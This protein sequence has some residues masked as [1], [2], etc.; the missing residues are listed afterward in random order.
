MNSKLA[1]VLLL[2]IVIVTGGCVGQTTTDVTPCPNDLQT[3]IQQSIPMV[4]TSCL[5]DYC[6]EIGVNRTMHLD[7]FSF[8]SSYAKG[9][10]TAICRKGSSAGQNINYLYCT[11]VEDS[12]KDSIY[13]KGVIPM[14]KV[15]IDSN[16]NI[17]QKIFIYVSSLVIDSDHNII[18][19]KCMHDRFNENLQNK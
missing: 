17:V 1:V 8:S 7:G 18:E 4:S 12:E 2:G 11:D 6:F 10:Y 19:L 3:I 13:N 15:V 14:Q 5:G 9:D 16:G